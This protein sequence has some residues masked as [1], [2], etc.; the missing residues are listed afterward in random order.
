MVE[1]LNLDNKVNKRKIFEELE[2]NNYSTY[3]D[4]VI[5]ANNKVKERLWISAYY[6]YDWFSVKRMIDEKVNNPVVNLFRDIYNNYWYLHND[7]HPWNIMVNWD[8]T[9]IIDFWNILEH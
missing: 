8:N 9:I 6:W 4:I 1:M 2:Q 3:M 7:F 5:K